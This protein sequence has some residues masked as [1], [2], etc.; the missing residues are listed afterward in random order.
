MG[1]IVPHDD[2]E[3]DMDSLSNV[4]DPSSTMHPRPGDSVSSTASLPVDIN[5]GVGTVDSSIY[6]EEIKWDSELEQEQEA[7]LEH[8]AA[9]LKQ[10]A[11]LREQEA[12]HREQ[13]RNQ[14]QALRNQQQALR[15]QLRDLR[16]KQRLRNENKRTASL[17]DH[18]DEHKK[19]ENGDNDDDDDNGQQRDSKP[20]AKR[21]KEM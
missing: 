6:S 20:A 2:H 16:V 7:L 11:V 21:H 12:A 1:D 18:P 17:Q 5:T 10:E 14:Q 9:L 19:K 13:I 4:T 8:Q 15:D 3:R